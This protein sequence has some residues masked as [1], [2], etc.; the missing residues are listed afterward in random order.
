M[1]Q[2]MKNSYRKVAG[3]MLT[4]MKEISGAIQ[5]FVNK[6]SHMSP[7]LGCIHPLDLSIYTYTGIQ[8]WSLLH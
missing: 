7:E 6:Q 8:Y 1:M 3:K 4:N 2:F 5:V